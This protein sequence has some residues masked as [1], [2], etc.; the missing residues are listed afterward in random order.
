MS[1][2][3]LADKNLI[4]LGYV[5]SS[6]NIL[7]EITNIIESNHLYGQKIKINL[8][9]LA[10]DRNQLSSLVSVIKSFDIELKTVYS[11]CLQTKIS[12]LEE[13]LTVSGQNYSEFSEKSANENQNIEFCA[14]EAIENILNNPA[15]PDFSNN[16]LNTVYIKQTLRSGMRV[17]N[18]GNVVI[19]GDCKAGSE[20]IATGDIT[21]WGILGGIAHAGSKGDYNASIRAFRINA[22]Q[23]RIADL[24]ARKPDTSELEKIDKNN[25][26]PEEAKISE[27]EIV[28]YSLNG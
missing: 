13:G 6:E 28:I 11:N 9:E 14:E 3:L 8:G 5:V 26:T 25:F 20:I 12:A 2:V 18:D 16:K 27:G 23:L 21:V 7:F 1:E 22:I 4:N 10:L 17:E 19:I 24:V 15:Q